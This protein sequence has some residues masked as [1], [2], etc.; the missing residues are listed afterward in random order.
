MEFG[1]QVM[2]GIAERLS[3]A[4]GAGGLRSLI[5]NLEKDSVL[6]APV[7]DGYIAISADRAGAL[8]VFEEIEP[9]IRQL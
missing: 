4:G 1:P 8:E 2:S 6:L 7:E 3:I 9:K 5:V